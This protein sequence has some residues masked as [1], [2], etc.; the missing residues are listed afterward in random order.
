M[1]LALIVDDSKT[2]AAIL[3]KML[4]KQQID[5]VVVESAE[6]A[7]SYLQNER[8]AMIFMDH[9]MP[10]M[11]GFDAVKAIKTDPKL[12]AIPVIMHTSKTGNIYVG[13]ARA[14]GAADILSKPASD[15]A[16]NDV[17]QRIEWRSQYV[18]KFSDDITEQVPELILEKPIVELEE[19]NRKS[20]SG[21]AVDTK[22]YSEEGNPLTKWLATAVLATLLLSFLVYGQVHRQLDDAKYQEQKLYEALAW[23]VTQ[24]SAY[25]LDELPFAGQRLTLLENLLAHLVAI[26]FQGQLVLTGHI[27]VFCLGEETTGIAEDYVLASGEQSLQDCKQLG[28]AKGEALLASRQQSEAFESFLQ[29]FSRLKDSSINI[30]V[31]GAGSDQPRYD[32]PEVIDGLVAGDWN[33]VALSNNRVEV[34]ILPE[35]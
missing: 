33:L 14:L 1:A 18:D 11:D 8:P 25:E 3:Q 13:H 24:A 4:K 21:E 15:A 2:S 10:G 5:S 7:I 26:G 12:T 34:K 30:L 19:E 31:E 20:L 6:L 23:A 35:K 29:D 17:L 22:T 28:L 32:Y 16:L 9:M 27:G